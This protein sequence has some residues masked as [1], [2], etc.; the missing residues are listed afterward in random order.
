M[1]HPDTAVWPKTVL[2]SGTIGAAELARR[3]ARQAELVCRH[4]LSNGQRSGS[5]WL[6]G[7]VHNAAGRSLYVRLT[8]AETGAGAAGKWTDAATGEHGDLLDIIAHAE[9][10]TTYRDVAHEAQRFLNMPALP[11]I[12]TGNRTPS[13]AGSTEAARRLYAMGVPIADT[14]AQTYLRFRGITGFAGCEALKFHPN[15]YYRDPVA[16]DHLQHPALIAAVTNSAGTIMGVQ[17]T[18]LRLDG[19]GKA[20]LMSPRRAMGRLLGFGVRLGMPIDRAISIM[21]AG[22]GIETMLSLRMALPFMP[23]AACLSAGNLGAFNLPGE[24]K[25]LYIA[26]DADSAGRAGTERLAERALAAGIEVLA[27]RPRLGDFNDDLRRLDFDTFRAGL[28]EQLRPEDRNVFMGNTR[29]R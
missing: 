25:R 10:L 4:Y 12:G 23:M 22:E 6:V 20:P 2:R 18:W 1:T 7:N 16:G 17:R 8:G 26:G 19:A 5:Y 3:L 29:C 15:C 9:Q 27:I 24:M 28:A 11:P 21:A 14:L 13:I